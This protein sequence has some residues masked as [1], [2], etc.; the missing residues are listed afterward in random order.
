[1]STEIFEHTFE[2]KVPARLRV[3]NV[4]GHVDVQPGE[5]GI[6]SVTAAKHQGSGSNGKT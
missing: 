3:S 6:I 2:V 5:E 1:M 4:R